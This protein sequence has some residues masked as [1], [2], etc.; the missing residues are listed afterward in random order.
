[1]IASRLTRPQA[2][3]PACNGQVIVAGT[4]TGANTA[5]KLQ[6]RKSHAGCPLKRET[7]SGTQSPHP[8][9]LA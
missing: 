8:Q 5:L 9:V 2:G 3:C 6:H 4:F 1:M 7:Y